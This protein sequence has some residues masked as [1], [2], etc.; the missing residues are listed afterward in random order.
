[1][2][3]PFDIFRTEP[4][5]NILWRGAATTLDEAKARVQ[6]FAKSGPSEYVIIN[7]QTG[8]KVTIAS[9]GHSSVGSPTNGTPQTQPES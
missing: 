2:E 4:D 8:L 1:M 5:G 6:E 3:T 9:E 7:L